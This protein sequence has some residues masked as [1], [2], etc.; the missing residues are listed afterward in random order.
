MQYSTL[1]PHATSF[2]PV[3]PGGGGGAGGSTVGDAV[4]AG[5]INSHCTVRVAHPRRD[6]YLNHETS[7][8][9]NVSGCTNEVLIDR[10]IY[11][12]GAT[13]FLEEGNLRADF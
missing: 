7:I 8:G 11:K 2:G 1:S 9:V 6:P 10:A 3:T 4:G 12:R 5:V 13:V